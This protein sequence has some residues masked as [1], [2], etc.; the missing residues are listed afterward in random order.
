MTDEKDLPRYV[1][2]EYILRFIRWMTPYRE[3]VSTPALEH[4]RGDNVPVLSEETKTLLGVLLRLKPPGRILEIGTAYGYSAIFMSQFL[5]PGGQ[6][7]TI[8]RNPVM[9]EQAKKHIRSAG[10]ADRVILY[11]GHAQELLRSMPGPYDMV[12]M[13]ASMG[14]YG[15]FWEEIQ[16]LLRADGWVMAD[17]VLHGGLVAMERL[18]VPRR[19]RTIHSRLRSF[20]ETVLQDEKYETSLLPVG[21]GILLSVRKGEN[22]SE[23]T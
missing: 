20:L 2:E 21:D 9:I 8:E 17:N 10:L 16:P 4:C 18:E 23:K 19:Q 22:K 1:G 5:R 12:L 7:H 3:D 14:Q 13:D 6:V 15:L 11:E